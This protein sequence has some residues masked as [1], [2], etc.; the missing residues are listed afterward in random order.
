MHKGQCNWR[1]GILGKIKPPSLQMFGL[2]KLLITS[3]LQANIAY[4]PTA[5]TGETAMRMKA[6]REAPARSRFLPAEASNR[7]LTIRVSLSML[8]N[9]LNGCLRNLIEGR[10][11]LGV[12][13][14][15]LL[16]DDQV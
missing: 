5:A 16:R 4:Q 14:I 11:R 9:E 12:S 13:F 1:A 7:C 10:E 6:G 3:I 8:A 15:S 2:D